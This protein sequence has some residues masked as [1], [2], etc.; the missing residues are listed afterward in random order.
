MHAFGTLWRGVWGKE[1]SSLRKECRERH[2]RM[3]MTPRIYE[4]ISVPVAGGYPGEWMLAYLSTDFTPPSF[5]FSGGDTCV[6]T[7]N[8]HSV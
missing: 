2:G 1:G 3:R 6:S 4:A 8:G 5:A 7:Q